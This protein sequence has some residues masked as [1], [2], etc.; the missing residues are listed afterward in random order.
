MNILAIESSA[1]AASAAVI[2]RAETPASIRI[3]VTPSVRKWQLPE[4]LLA[5]EKYFSIN[6]VPFSILLG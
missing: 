1:V 2:F 6:Y 3:L 5:M 4:E